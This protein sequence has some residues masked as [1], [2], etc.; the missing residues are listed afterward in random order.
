MILTEL[1]AKEL[2]L[3][4]TLYERTFCQMAGHFSR[5]IGKLSIIRVQLY[6]GLELVVSG[7]RVMAAADNKI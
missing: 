5:F 3:T 6:D 1:L 4:I 2:G 7:I